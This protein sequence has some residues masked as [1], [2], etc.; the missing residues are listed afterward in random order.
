[1]F[2]CF[3]GILQAVGNSLMPLIFLIISSITNIG[4]DLLFIGVFKMGVMGASVAT[5][6]AQIMS[7]IL[8]LIFLLRKGTVYQIKFR[9]LRVH[10][11][12][13]KKILYYGIPAG[14]QN[15]VIGLANVVVQ[16]NIN[17]FGKVAMAGCGIYSK[18]EG[19][20]FLPVQSFTM[21]LTTFTGQNLGAKQYDRAKRGATFGIITSIVTAEIIGT[22]TFFV[23]PYLARMFSTT[24]EVIQIAV[25]QSREISL[26]YC[27]LAFSHC[28]AAI[29]RGAG[30]AIIP[31]VIMLSVWC[32]FRVAFVSIAMSINHDLS[33]LF[34]IYPITWGISSIIYLFIHLFSDWVHGFEKKNKQ[35]VAEPEVKE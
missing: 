5:G 9:E 22:I 8:C 31:M 4:L 3:S 27:L 1:M 16:S 7:A 11:E 6:V 15:S 33:L 23:A 24:E 2:N 29:Q 28:A 13:L 34:A 35:A 32:V 19:F 17:T 30:R 14:I 26:F 10:K 20:A 12:S 21:A 25:H 18:I